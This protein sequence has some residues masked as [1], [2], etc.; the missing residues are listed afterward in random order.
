MDG[1]DEH[2]LGSNED[3]LKIIKGQKLLYLHVLVTSRPHNTRSLERY[4]ETIIRING[5]TRL[6]A[7]QFASK[8]LADQGKVEDLLNFNPAN[9]RQDIALYQSPLLLSFMCLLVRADDIDLSSKT[10]DTGEICTKM[11]HCLYK[12]FTIRENKNFE[13]NDFVRTMKQVGKIAFKTLSSGNYLLRRS[14]VIR[15]IGG[16]A[17]NYVLFAGLEDFR[18]LQDQTADI[19]VTFIHPSIQEFLGSFYFVV[20]LSQGES[21]ESL[22]GSD[23]EKPIFMMNPSFLHFCLW[24][25]RRGQ[26][27]SA[28]GFPSEVY[29]SLQN[30]AKHILARSQ[31]KI[32]DIPTM[33]EVLRIPPARDELTRNF[34][35]EILTQEKGPTQTERSFRFSLE[36]R[37]SEERK[38]TEA[39]GFAGTAGAS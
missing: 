26:M 25:L 20:M 18:L 29:R 12:K 34:Y 36:A 3:V 14:Q 4:F 16:D 38:L 6:N 15:D 30:F 13:N 2:A 21:I 39:S 27:F 31:H 28:L 8:N 19:I 35:D 9:F 1:L 33:Y 11:I 37:G 5:F 10:I 24:F 17:F 32:L 22:L 7:E 23:C